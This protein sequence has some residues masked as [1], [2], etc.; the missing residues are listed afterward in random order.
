[1]ADA[2]IMLIEDTATDA[3][4]TIRALR[5][6][7]V[8]N[9][10][11]VAR[12]GQEAIDMLF[13]DRA[14]AP[15]P[16]LILLDLKLPRLSGFEVLRRI[17]AD[18]AYRRIPVVVLTSSRQDPDIERAYGLGAT[19]Y[20]VKPVDFAQFNETVKSVGYYWLMANVPPPVSV[21]RGAV[22][23]PGSRGPSS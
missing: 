10:I 2:S 15:F 17:R 3:E 16:T 5:S 9:E 23:A 22:A 4:L 13:G 12:D 19:S 18:D 21:T 7:A 6:A 8:V 11:I 20:I 14:V 1:M